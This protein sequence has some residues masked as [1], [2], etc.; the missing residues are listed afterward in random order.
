MKG[1]WKPESGS[2]CYVHIGNPCSGS[3]TDF[4]KV[5]VKAFYEGQVWMQT[6]DNVEAVVPVSDCIFKPIEKVSGK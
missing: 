4:N 6:T 1:M 3:K 5:L 2:E